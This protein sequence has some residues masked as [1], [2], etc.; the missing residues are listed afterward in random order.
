MPNR[1]RYAA[2]VCA[3]ALMLA[4]PGMFA[5]AQ[6]DEITVY[7]SYEEDELEM[8]DRV[9]RPAID[10]GVVDWR[11]EVEQ[12]ERDRLMAGAYATLMLGAWPEP[13]GL[14]A[15]E[16]MATGTPVI[17][18]RAGG[19]TE[20]V[21]HGSTGF[22][23]DDVGEATLAVERIPAIRRDRVAAYARGR[24]SADR[25]TSLYEAAYAEVL[26]ARSERAPAIPVGSGAALGGVQ[27][28]PVRSDPRHGGTQRRVVGQLDR[29]DRGR[30]IPRRQQAQPLVKGDP[31][32]PQPLCLG[33]EG[34]A[35]RLPLGGEL[36]FEIVPQGRT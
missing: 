29:D 12:E 6:A 22:L 4:A 13:F 11:G 14:V 19:V 10:D 27:G 17:A 32:Q 1:F 20:T 33:I 24:F 16:S 23:V 5:A 26:A 8:L 34:R 31:R 36:I 25:M 18:R 21:E 3:T 2:G 30:S 7:T 28:H 9:V 15:I 35:L